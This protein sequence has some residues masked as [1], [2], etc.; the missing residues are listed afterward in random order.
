ME[1]SR[2]EKPC[3]SAYACAASSNSMQGV[4]PLFSMYCTCLAISPSDRGG[5][6]EKVSKNLQEEEEER[7][8]AR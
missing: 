3:P 7:E 4:H 5:R 1:E 6:K 2:P 8:A